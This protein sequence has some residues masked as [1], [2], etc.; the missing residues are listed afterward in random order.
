MDCLLYDCCDLSEVST[1][2]LSYTHFTSTI[3]I[4]GNIVS[5]F[6]IVAMQNN[7]ELDKITDVST[8]EI[9][10][11]NVCRLLNSNDA[12]IEHF[13]EIVYDFV[14]SENQ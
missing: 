13:R 7:L 3:E 8:S 2:K 5:T 1:T 14:V 6:G 12:H 9:F 4:E 10:A 11:K